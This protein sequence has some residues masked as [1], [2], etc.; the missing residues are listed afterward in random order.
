M[1]AFSTVLTQNQA[2]K[3]IN[4]N[5]P[6]LYGEQ[7]SIQVMTVSTGLRLGSNWG[8]W[9]M[10]TLHSSTVLLYITA[11]CK[12]IKGELC[13]FLVTHMHLAAVT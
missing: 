7:V 6:I 4:L 8:L 12:P 5:R 13:H 2:I 1:I 9:Y 10:N 3:G 11:A